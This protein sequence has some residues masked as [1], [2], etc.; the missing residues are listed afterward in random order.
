[1]IQ[2]IAA[3]VDGDH[4]TKTERAD[5]FGVPRKSLCE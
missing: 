2:A 1:M 3:W 4:P 5:A